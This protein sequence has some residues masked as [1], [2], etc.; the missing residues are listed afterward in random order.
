MYYVG[1]NGALE[2]V[3]GKVINGY[4]VADVNHFSHYAALEYDKIYTD[5]AATFWASDVIKQL[6]A[7][8]IITGINDTQYAPLRDVSRAEFAA[9]IVRS[10]QLKS[11]V[12][13]IFNDVSVSKWYANDIAAAYEA[14][15][16]TGYDGNRFAPEA[17]ITRQEMAVMMLRAY[18]YASGQKVEISPSDNFTDQDQIST[19]AKAAV[20]AIHSIGIIEGNNGNIFNP[21]GNLNRAESAKVIFELLTALETES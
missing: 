20:N 14:G 6:S 15:I 9:L 8:H 4:I 13:P 2:Y 21:Q 1:E 17:S 10:L 18:E 5:V 12:Q 11:S 16:I 7:K 3:G 19:W